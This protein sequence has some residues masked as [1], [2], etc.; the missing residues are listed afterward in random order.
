MT[1][2]ETTDPT[3]GGET[4][5]TQ[6]T[7][8]R[9]IKVGN[10][11]YDPSTPEGIEAIERDMAAQVKGLS[12]QGQTI[13]QLQKQLA[14][15]QA[16]QE[17]PE[18]QEPIDED[19]QRAATRKVLKDMGFKSADEL[20]PDIIATV[21]AQIIQEQSVAAFNGALDELSKNSEKYPGY[22]EAAVIQRG[23]EL[24]WNFVEQY[25]TT[26][27][28]AKRRLLIAY[29]DLRDEASPEAS[30]QTTRPKARTFQERPQQKPD[31]SKPAASPRPGLNDDGFADYLRE[32]LRAG[33][34]E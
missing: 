28:E 19:E 1:V 24:G 23:K 3:T 16:A 4:A 7:E 14:D 21:K 9:V 18:E 30:A 32:E 34:A 13:A 11:E 27:G 29:R 5:E 6:G 2:P 25:G 12:G 20:T 22:D 10:T 17:T 26:Q 8:P 33:Q 31:R 15:A